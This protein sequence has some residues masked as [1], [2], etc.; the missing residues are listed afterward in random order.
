MLSN[1]ER[2]CSS[3]SV[4]GTSSCVL[5]YLDNF[6]LKFSAI[7]LTPTTKKKFAPPLYQTLT[8][9]KTLIFGGLELIPNYFVHK[10]EFVI[11]ETRLEKL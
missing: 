3:G 9:K 1:L 7:S 11:L 10:L 2:R 6:V 5:M 8:K 4:A